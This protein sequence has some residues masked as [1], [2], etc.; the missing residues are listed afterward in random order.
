MVDKMTTPE[1]V[2]D[3][4]DNKVAS[5]RNYHL[6]YDKILEKFPDNAAIKQRLFKHIDGNST[7]SDA[8]R[9]ALVKDY[10]K[11]D[12]NGNITFDQTKLPAGTDKSKV[13]YA[14]PAEC[15]DGDAKKYFDAALK[16]Y[17]K[18]ELDKIAEL[19]DKNPDSV[20]KHIVSLVKQNQSDTAFIVEVLK[21]DKTELIPYDDIRNI[22]AAAAKWDDQTKQAVFEKTYPGKFQRKDWTKALQN[23]INK[24][25]ISKVTEQYYSI[26]NIMYD[27]MW[28]GNGADG[29]DNTQDDIMF[30]QRFSKTGYDNGVK[31]FGELKGAGSGD[32]AKMLRSKKEEGYENFVTPDNVV[33]IICGFNTK[34]PKEG[35]MQYI[36][37][38]N[39]WSAGKKPGKALCN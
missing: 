30:A 17:G 12:G 32:I 9:L 34:S 4:I 39:G 3:F 35:L 20:K 1:E 36:A 11:D 6:P 2:I 27:T 14:L 15:K 18:G 25:L 5:D 28:Y 31:M 38:E 33:G 7:I 29:K 19:K 13:M 24:H 21:L 16:T 26:G 37:N 22:D 23:A 10:M 8:N